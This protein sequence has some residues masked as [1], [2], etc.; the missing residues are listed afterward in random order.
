MAMQTMT[1]A[2]QIILANFPLMNNL[3]LRGNISTV[4][5]E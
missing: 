3:L 5:F 2:K 4:A 1:V